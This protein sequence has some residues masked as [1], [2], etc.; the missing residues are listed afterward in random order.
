MDGG[1]GIRPDKENNFLY[2]DKMWFCQHIRYI[3]KVVKI[4]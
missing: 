4:R 2:G 3:V 1:T